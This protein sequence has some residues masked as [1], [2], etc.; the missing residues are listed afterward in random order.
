VSFR[1]REA[2]AELVETEPGL[3]PALDP[4]QDVEVNGVFDHR[5]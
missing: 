2:V 4:P 5:I 3:Q 1:I